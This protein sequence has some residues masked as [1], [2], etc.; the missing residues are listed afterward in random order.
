MTTDNPQVQWTDEQWARVNKVIQEEAS[1]ARVAATFLPLIGPLPGDT[2]FVRAEVIS[3]PEISE[4][5]TITLGGGQPQ[6]A[7]IGPGLL[8]QRE[9][10]HVADRVIIKLATLQVRVPVRGA[11]IADPEM[12]SVLALFRR[13]ANVLARLEDLVV[14]RGLDAN[15]TPVGGPGGL[16]SVW[17]IHGGE[18]TLGLWGNPANWPWPAPFPQP[19]PW[20]WVQLQWTS[21]SD[22]GRALVI[23]VSSAI[24][25]LEAGGH[26]GPFA[27]V[28]G[29]GL[30]LIAQT[31]GGDGY[32]LP[33][34]RIIPFLGGGSL[35][36]SSTLSD[37]EG[38]SGVVVALGGAPIELVVATDM[39]LQF[40]Q[41]TDEPR[42]LFRVRER[43]ALRVKDADAIVRLYPAP[44]VTY[45]PP[46]PPG[47]RRPRPAGPG[48]QAQAPQAQAPQAQAPQA[49]APQAQAPQAQAPQAQAAHA[50]E[51]NRSHGGHVRR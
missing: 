13:A 46:P 30:F 36:R 17:E 25:A 29:Q 3:Y 45:P 20:Q 34:D 42:Y 14:F 51:D 39:S 19:K 37:Y 16:P 27:V 38:C 2:D 40:L 12:Q 24:G 44:G 47:S 48:P 33:Q 9:N 28:L 35:L 31:P 23:A 49:Q 5:E 11:Q 7:T 15:G 21:E 43:I 26:F 18:A 4:S 41:V 8:G 50:T 32:A 1:H 6:P 22:A 10:I